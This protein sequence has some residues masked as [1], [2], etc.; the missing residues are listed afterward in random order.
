MNPKVLFVCAAIGALAGCGVSTA[1]MRPVPPAPTQSQS[2]TVID[3]NYTLGVE[4]SAYVGEAIVRVRDRIIVTE[5]QTN[6]LV[7]DR[8]FVWTGATRVPWSVAAN[9][10]LTVSGIILH[11]SEQ[12][13]LLPTP[14]APCCALMVRMDGTSRGDVYMPANGTVISGWES[15]ALTPPDVRFEMKSATSERELPG[16]TNFE[17]VYTGAA[18]DSLT[19]L[20]REYTPNDLARDAFSQ[21]LTYSRRE[22]EIRF[23]KLLVRV[24][25]VD[26]QSIRY[27]VIEDGLA[28][29][30]GSSS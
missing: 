7:P 28:P 24:V 10:P 1:V 25:A 26:N 19:F 20:Y 2:R 11:N 17:L 30:L 15:M 9:Q 12:Y 5:T 18:G 23:R 8:A 14:H 16:T 21:Q 6:V 4:Q 3:R 13:R 29:A 22:P 27:V